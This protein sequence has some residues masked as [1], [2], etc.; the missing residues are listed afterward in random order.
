M[1]D[2]LCPYCG[3]EVYE[4]DKDRVSC[5]DT[6][7]CLGHLSFS[8][9]QWNRRFVCHDEHGDKVFAGDSFMYKGWLFTSPQ[10]LTMVSGKY[11]PM[12]KYNDGNIWPLS[13]LFINDNRD[14][15]CSYK[16]IELIK[17]PEESGKI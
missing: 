12:V 7:C 5:G 4:I 2:K 1:S 15:V 13:Y 10:R 11:G 16:D 17:E 8:R 3:T 14:E 6:D 9:K